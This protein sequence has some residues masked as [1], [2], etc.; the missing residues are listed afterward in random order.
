MHSWQGSRYAEFIV[1][2]HC[3]AA[4]IPHLDLMMWFCRELN[5]EV[6]FHEHQYSRHKACLCLTGEKQYINSEMF[7]DLMVIFENVKIFICMFGY[8]NIGFIL[9]LHLPK[10]NGAEILFLTKHEFNTR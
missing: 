2:L 5:K 3:R 4:T 8:R 10:S 6:S 1:V 7:T 9:F